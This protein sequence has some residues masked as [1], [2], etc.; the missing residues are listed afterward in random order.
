MKRFLPLALTLV[1]AFMFIFTLTLQVM[2]AGAPGDP[3]PLYPSYSN[4]CGFQCCTIVNQCGNTGRGSTF[5]RI[6]NWSPRHS[7]TV[8]TCEYFLPNNECIRYKCRPYLMPAN[9]PPD[10]S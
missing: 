2:A 5:I 1:F 3:A 7:D 6:T 8:V 4:G 10:G 9:C